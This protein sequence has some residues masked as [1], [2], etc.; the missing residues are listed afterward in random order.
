M[1]RGIGRGVNLNQNSKHKCKH[2]VIFSL[3]THTFFFLKEGRKER[4]GAVPPKDFYFLSG[5]RRKM[6]YE[7]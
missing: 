2:T 5:F 1:E 4:K 3:C 6:I 7:E